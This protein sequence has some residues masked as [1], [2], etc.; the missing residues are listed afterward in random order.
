MKLAKVIG[1]VVCTQKHESFAGAKLVLLQPVDEN[2]EKTGDPIVG[3]DLLSACTG[4]LIY[5]ETSKEAG[6]ILETVMNPCDVAVMG[7][8]DDMTVE[9]GK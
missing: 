8:I 6:R 5:Y 4:D 9:T 7:I 1:N 2:L 3:I